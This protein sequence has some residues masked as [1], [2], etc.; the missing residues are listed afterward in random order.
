MWLHD[1][2]ILWDIDTYVVWLARPSKTNCQCY[3]ATSDNHHKWICEGI[4]PDALKI[5]KVVP[6]CKKDSPDVFGNYRPV[7]VLPCF[8]KI[9]ER[10]V[11]DRCCSFLEINNILHNRQYGFRHQHSTWLYYILL[12]TSM[13]LLIATNILTVFSWTYQKPLILSTTIFCYINFIIMV[14]EECTIIGLLTTLPIENSMCHIIMLYH[15]MKMFYVEYPKVQSLDHCCLSYIWMIFVV[16]QG[17]CLLYCLQMIQL[18]FTL[19]MILQ[20]LLKSWMM[21]LM[22]L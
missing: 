1:N 9:Y 4:V 18:Y 15:P 12:K 3:I 16:H 20:N 22:K 6:I 5:A 2:H 21:N 11:H 14:F 7:S 10:I 8:S 17:F 19:I 13:K